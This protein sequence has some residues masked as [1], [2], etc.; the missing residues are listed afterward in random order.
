MKGFST[1]NYSNPAAFNAFA[2]F[3]FREQ[4][5]TTSQVNSI[6][7]ASETEQTQTKA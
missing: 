3:G 1:E 6:V 2:S 5:Q 4:W 7:F